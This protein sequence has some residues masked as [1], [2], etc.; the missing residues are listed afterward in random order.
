MAM[1]FNFVRYERN[2]EKCR[3]E[4]DFVAKFAG[5]V[6]S[7]NE[8][9]GQLSLFYS[10]AEDTAVLDRLQSRAGRGE[11]R[12]RLRIYNDAES[13]KRYERAEKTRRR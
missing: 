3:T 2:E 5:P 9:L 10:C 1:D 6:P 8:L 7:K 12:G 13:L 11:V 4:I